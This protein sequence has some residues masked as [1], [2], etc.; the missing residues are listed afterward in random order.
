MHCVLWQTM[1][2]NVK[3]FIFENSS[4]VCV[5]TK[6][7]ETGRSGWESDFISK[8]L[9]FNLNIIMELSMNLQWIL[10]F[11]DISA[12]RTFICFTLFMKDIVLPF[13]FQKSI[14]PQ[15]CLHFC[16]TMC[17]NMCRLTLGFDTY[18]SFLS[19]WQTKCGYMNL[20]L[21]ASTFG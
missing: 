17:S 21:M 19:L 12:C 8:W 2:H 15:Q 4:F 16:S 5:Q 1:K 9:H 20:F 14:F 6:T 11:Q 13:F 10:C 18:I 7:K 3:H